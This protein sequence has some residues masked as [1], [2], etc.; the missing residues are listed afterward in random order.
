M[1]IQYDDIVQD[2]STKAKSAA[3][4]ISWFHGVAATYDNTTF[5][6]SLFLVNGRR[7]GSL[8]E[9]QESM[10]QQPHGNHLRRGKLRSCSSDCGF[11]EFGIHGVGGGG[12][13][14]GLF[15][16]EGGRNV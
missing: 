10:A 7:S 5:F 16:S 4:P 1:C 13:G 15:G 14:E 9:V 2:V 3:G 12:V 8:F 11:G 6:G